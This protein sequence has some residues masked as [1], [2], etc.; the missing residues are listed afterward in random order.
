MWNLSTRRRRNRSRPAFPSGFENWFHLKIRT[1]RT[2]RKAG[3]WDIAIYT[4]YCKCRP[5]HRR[6]S[7]IL[8]RQVGAVWL[9]TCVINHLI[10]IYK[11]S[12][13]FLSPSSGYKNR[14]NVTQSRS[15]QWQILFKNPAQKHKLY[16]L[17]QSKSNFFPVQS[18][19]VYGGVELY[20]NPLF[21]APVVSLKKL[22]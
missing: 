7:D 9:L 13:N 17:L 19:K 16:N 2:R 21:Y 1:K 10:D 12:N 14:F 4:G 6:S 3:R 22:A 15:L 11:L 5:G 8:H 20:T 18:V